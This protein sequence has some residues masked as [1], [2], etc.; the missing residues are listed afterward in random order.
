MPVTELDS[1]A[2]LVIIDLQKGIVSIPTAHA[3]TEIIDRSAQLARA[4]RKRGLPVVLV[5]VTA[6]APGRTDSPRP[7]VA[8]FPPDWAEL[9]AALDQQPDDIAITKQRW[10][11]F[12]GTSLDQ[13]LRQRGVTQIF[14]AGIATSAGVESAGRSAFDLGYHVVFVADAMTDRDPDTHKH[15]VEKVFPRIGQVDNTSHV[16]E[17]LNSQQQQ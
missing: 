10:G 16:L 1:T 8:A 17:L 11:A 6:A 14:F 13:T 3:A 5:N 4:F 7:N 9:V 2:A 12:I 15:C